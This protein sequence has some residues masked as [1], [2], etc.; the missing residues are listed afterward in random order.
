MSSTLVSCRR[1]SC[2]ERVEVEENRTINRTSNHTSVWAH[3][4]P[5]NWLDLD[6]RV[7]STSLHT[8]RWGP[9]DTHQKDPHDGGPRCSGTAASS[10]PVYSVFRHS[11]TQLCRL[12]LRST[13]P[14]TVP[15]CYL[16]HVPCIS[17]CSS[18]KIF[19]YM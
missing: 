19:P 1:S 13:L 16:A 11:L 5:S 9:K 6:G 3:F 7:P 17:V 18:K 15:L 10:R 8:G 4:S 2:F 14:C 12:L